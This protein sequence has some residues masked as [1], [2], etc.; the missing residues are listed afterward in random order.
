VISSAEEWHE[1]Q[2]IIEERY[3]DTNAKMMTS[4]LS[5]ELSVK[6]TELLVKHLASTPDLICILLVA[7]SSPQPTS[8]PESP[9]QYRHQY[10]PSGYEAYNILTSKVRD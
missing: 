7:M 2:V 6:T 4:A 3:A 1:Q 10:N 8:I 9:V 5:S